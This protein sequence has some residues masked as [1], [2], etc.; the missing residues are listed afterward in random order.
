MHAAIS[1]MPKSLT[2]VLAMAGTLAAGIAGGYVAR[3]GGCRCRE[4]GSARFRHH[5][6]RRPRARRCA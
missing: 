1:R 6:A 3:Y 4:P 5:G 2:A